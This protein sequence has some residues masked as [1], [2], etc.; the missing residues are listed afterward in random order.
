MN[1]NKIKNI[2][3]KLKSTKKTNRV[4]KYR[5]VFLT[6]L[7]VDL[8]FLIKKWKFLKDFTRKMILLRP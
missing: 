1:K 3:F 7:K 4:I 5:R 8:K 2:N 6:R